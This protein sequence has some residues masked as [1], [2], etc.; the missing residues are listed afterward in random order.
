MGYCSPLAGFTFT[1][2]GSSHASV[3]PMLLFSSWRKA[4]L[5]RH[6]CGSYA[7]LS[8][9]AFASLLI[10]CKINTESGTNGPLFLWKNSNHQKKPNQKQIQ[11]HPLLAFSP[12]QSIRCLQIVIIPSHLINIAIHT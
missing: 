9:S 10:G 2:T 6:T 7:A 3:K 11:Q 1:L 8:F 4:S 5:A 12:N